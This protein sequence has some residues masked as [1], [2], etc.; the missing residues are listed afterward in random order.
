M[1]K[2]LLLTFLIVLTSYFVSSQNLHTNSNAASILNE[3][4]SVSGWQTNVRAVAS[5]SAVNPFSGSFSIR[6]ASIQVRGG[7]AFYSFPANI[8]QEYNISIWAREGSSSFQ[9]AFANWQGLSGFTTT[10]ISG[11][12]WTEYSWTL[13]AT[14]STPEIRIYT[15]PT[16]GGQA[17]N[18]VFF[19]NVSI[20]PVGGDTTPPSNPANLVAGN[21]TDTSVDLSWDASTDAVGVTDYLVYNNGALLVA[22]GSTATTYTVTGLTPETAYSLTVRAVDAATNES[23]DSNA[24]AFNTTASPDL[25]APTAPANLVAG[26]ITDTSVD[27]SWDAST[28]AVGVTDYLVYNNGAL[29]VATG[30]TATTYTVTGLTPETAYSLTVRAVDAATNESGDSNTQA[31]NTTASPDL[32]APTAPANLVAGNI[33]D[34]SVDLSWDASTDAVGVTDYLV[35]NNGALLVATG[36]TATTYT[37]TGLTPETAYSLTVRAVDAATNESGDSNAQAF[38]T[39]ASPDL[40]AP[41][42]PANLVAGNITD[43]S[44]DLSWDASTDAVGVTDYLV[45]NNGALLVATGSTATTYTVTGLTP[46]TAYSLTVRAVDAATN[47][48]GDSNAQAFNTTA[49]PDLTAPTAPANLVA[50]NI[51]DTSVDLSWDASTDAVGVTDYLVY[52]NGALLVATGSTATTYTVT[53][54]TP[55]TAYSLTVRAVDAATNESGDSNAQAFNTTAS[56]DLTA[57]TAPAN[58]VA[59]NITDTSVDL[60]W[61]ASTD[62]VGVTDYLVYNNGAL[63]VATGSTATT[64][65]VTGLTPETAYSLTVRAVDAATNESGDSNAQAFNTTASPDLT[66]PT[67]PANLVAGNITD[68]SVDLSWDAST[69]AVG[70]TDYLVY[71]N[72]ALLVATGSTA[73]TYTVTGLTPET[74]YSLTVRAVDAATNESGDSNAQAFNTTASPDLTAPTAPANLVAGNITDTSVD[75]SWDASTDAVGVTDYLVYN[76]GALLVATGSTATTYT[77]TG[78]TPETAYSLTVRAV[79]AA[80]NES[81]DSN[82]QAFNTANSVFHYTEENANL[83]TV[84]WQVRDLIAARNITAASILVNDGIYDANWDGSLEVPTKNAIYDKIETL[85]SNGGDVTKAGTPVDNQIGVWTGDGTLEGTNSLTFNGTNILINGS[86]LESSPIWSLSGTDISYST[87]NVGIGTS[88][89]PSAYRLAVAGGIIAEEI[90]VQLQINWPDYVFDKEYDLLSLEEVQKHIAD[91]G[92]LPNMPSALEVRQK[93]INLGEM[94]AKLLQKIEELTLYILEQ[95]RKIDSLERQNQ[96]MEMILDRLME[97]ENQVTNKE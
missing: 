22:T 70:V 64:Y 21:I 78:L 50:G 17:G 95:Q 92:Y 60:S 35:Y 85:S 94:D 55:E 32:T 42:A 19:D 16:S 10:I 37:V 53:G 39:T 72:G 7:Y 91:K 82:A 12:S 11:S 14:V 28:D 44:V 69:D 36:S 29:L 4:N 97:L 48:S 13:T 6:V 88:T 79:D 81:G 59:G 71:N 75:L 57:P 8:G 83:P 77:V 9:P 63:L 87:G 68:T 62:A 18:E 76:N 47:E 96:K 90:Q 45:Y 30:S 20:F 52:N 51:T 38:N 34:T 43:T 3:A 2:K 80:T 54:L 40:T 61:D 41:T 15:S 26:N 73:T 86:P 67:A 84:D 5:S 27:L 74:A 46:E 56:P 49:S 58:L 25:T 66:A 89:I 31:F 65:T 23:G 24:Q 33:T 93:G 1:D